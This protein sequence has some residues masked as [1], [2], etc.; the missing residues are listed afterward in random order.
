MLE[1]RNKEIYV[2]AFK[3]SLWYILLLHSVLLRKTISSKMPDNAQNIVF[4]ENTTISLVRSGT[5]QFVEI[6]HYFKIAVL[7][8]SSK[9]FFFFLCWHIIQNI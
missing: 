5:L 4:K 2:L 9:G 6:F 7:S 1:L 3:V 8:F